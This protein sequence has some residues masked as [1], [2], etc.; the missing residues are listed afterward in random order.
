[1]QTGMHLNLTSHWQGCVLHCCRVKDLELLHILQNWICKGLFQPIG[2]D[3]HST[4]VRLSAT[5]LVRSV[6]LSIDQVIRMLTIFCKTLFVTHFLQQEHIL[7]IVAALQNVRPQFS[8]LNS[9]AWP[10]Y[11]HAITAEVLQNDDESQSNPAAFTIVQFLEQCLMNDS[12]GNC[13]VQTLDAIARMLKRQITKQ[14]ESLHTKK[15]VHLCA[16][17]AA[18]SLKRQNVI[19]ATFFADEASRLMKMSWHSLLLKRTVAIEPNEVADFVVVCQCA[20]LNTDYIT[21]HGMGTKIID[22]GNLQSYFCHSILHHG[23][24]LKALT[25]LLHGT[26][27]S[28]SFHLECALAFG[29]YDSLDAP[30]VVPEIR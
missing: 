2:Q 17:F 14:N 6:I 5:A 18:C 19:A 22:A 30:T 25:N 16:L 10:A 26:V 11:V 12:L 27:R 8:A 4:S 28:S 15:H 7:P 13:E 20:L 3:S 1:M 21:A 23:H 9:L 24:V 29:A